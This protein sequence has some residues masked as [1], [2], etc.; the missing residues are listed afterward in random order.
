MAEHDR[1]RRVVDGV[2]NAVWS[3]PAKRQ[4][5][6]ALPIVDETMAQRIIDL[7]MRVAEVML[8]VGASAKEV[9]LAVLRITAAYGLRSVH[10]N[11]TFNSV[12]LSDHR[13]GT[14]HPIT[15]M[16]VVRA[17]VPDHAKLQRLQALVNDIESGLPLNEAVTRFHTIRRTPFMYRT[18]VVVV[19]QALLAV[20]V[21]LMF[22]ASWVILLAVFLAGLGV[23]TSQVLLGKARVPLFFSQIV[24]ALVLTAIT[25]LLAWLGANGV[26]PF[27]G[28]RSSLVVSSGIVLLLAGLAVVGA[29]QDAI[30]GFSLTAGGRLLDLTVMTMGVVL[31][32]L[33]A[34]EIAGQ[35][36]ASLEVPSEATAM[37]PAFGQAAGAVVIAAAVAIMN[38]SGMRII[39]VSAG[40]GLLGW[41][42][43]YLLGTVLLAP[44]SAASFGGALVASFVGS[45]VA[46]RLKVPS[47]AVTTAAIIPMVPGAAVFRGLLGVVEAGSDTAALM[48]AFDALF[49]AGMIGIALAAGA[50]LGIFLGSPLRARIGGRRVAL[51]SKARG[52]SG[53]AGT[54]AFEVVPAYRTT[55]T[56][57]VPQ[58]PPATLPVAEASDPHPITKP[59]DEAVDGPL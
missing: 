24:G 18:G 16:Q 56:T 59:Y 43:W 20:A 7:A 3:D 57:P 23:A 5:T 25:V 26:E 47:V 1:A 39:A 46:D 49:T 4:M 2:K 52:G 45:L 12:T 50:T 9:V 51:R 14:G 32:I 58:D 48:A 22:G 28:V 40:L 41:G 33:V 19:V 35:I 27:D 44:S 21:A 54:A 31:G 15:V 17:A 10:T 36:G 42:G 6:E 11:V 38:G 37:G 8:S 29:A 30:D 34:L 13:N 53:A 55:E